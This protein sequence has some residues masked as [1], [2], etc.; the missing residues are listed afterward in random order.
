MP[1]A[2]AVHHI[3]SGHPQS[4]IVRATLGRITEQVKVE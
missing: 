1:G 3:N 2:G 4:H